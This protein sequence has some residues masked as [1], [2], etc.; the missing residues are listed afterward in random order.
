MFFQI[1]NCFSAAVKLVVANTRPIGPNGKMILG[2]LKSS[3]KCKLRYLLI[4]FKTT[5]ELLAQSDLKYN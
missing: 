4:S 5:V 3:P 2:P 1:L